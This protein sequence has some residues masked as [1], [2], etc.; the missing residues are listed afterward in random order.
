MAGAANGVGTLVVSL[1]ASQEPY[2]GGVVT[3]TGPSGTVTDAY[4]T[5]SVLTAPA[6][7]KPGDMVPVTVTG[8]GASESV[9]LNLDA[10]TV[11]TVTTN[12]VGTWSGTVKMQPYFGSHVL[13]ATGLTSG[14][15]K[16][17]NM[18]FDAWIKLTPPNG[19]VGTVVQVSSGPGWVPNAQ[20]HV[21][22]RS[23]NVGNPKVGGA[24]WVIYSFTIPDG[25][26]GS[27][28]PVKVTDDGL[29][30]SAT[31]NFLVGSAGNNPP[32]LSSVTLSPTK[33]YPTT[34]ITAQA[35]GVSDPEGDPVT[36]HYAWTVNG[37][38]VA[39]NDNAVLP[40]TKFT[41]NDSVA[42]SVTP[43]D[44]KGASGTP[45]A[46]TP[47]VVSWNITAITGYPGQSKALNAFGF[48]PGETVDFRMDSPTGPVMW[49]YTAD[50]SGE[51]HQTVTLPPP[52]PAAPTCCTARAARAGSPD[53]GR[54]P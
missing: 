16:T 51:V 1:V 30:L 17:A 26:A 45:V 54:S 32:Q 48:T 5:K 4:T 6:E 38:P 52:S 37:N 43:T 2:P 25:S 19:P 9:K 20:A 39:A 22:W 13:T 46:S 11:A 3:V 8:F 29:G 21:F 34:P 36:L 15:S 35:N 7:N 42:V 18:D 47:K 28:Y 53:P 27:S 50:S 40:T 10:T 12:S 49:T 31:A 33:A 44:S 23:G 14:A 24:G 41:G